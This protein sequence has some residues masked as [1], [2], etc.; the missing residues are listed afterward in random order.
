MDY[1]DR[2]T[3]EQAARNDAIFAARENIAKK[4]T[5][6]PVTTCVDEFSFVGLYRSDAG[7]CKLLANSEKRQVKL[8]KI[9]NGDTSTVEHCE[10]QG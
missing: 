10:C 1:L 6:K 5:D 2:I 4:T 7:W 3:E 9:E 8:E